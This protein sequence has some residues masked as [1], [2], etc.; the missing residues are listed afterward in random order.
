MKK[1]I[2]FSL[3]ILLGLFS[4]FSVLGRKDEYSAEK[5]FWHISQDFSKLTKDAKTTPD[6]AFQN[7]IIQ[8]NK[9]IKKFPDSKLLPKIYILKAKAYIF[10][11]EY[12]EARKNL[13]DVIIKYK[14]YPQI[15]VKALEFILQSY[16]LEGDDE[17]ILKTYDRIIKDYPVTSLGLK[18]PL[19]ISQF[20]IQK[21]Q[22]AKAKQA[23]D[24]A[25]QHYLALAKEYSESPVQYSILEITVTC[26]LSQK[27]WKQAV[28]L[29]AEMLIKFPSAQYLTTLRRK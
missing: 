24:D 1:T 26:Y 14:D 15:V 12:K 6:A 16:A 20:Y 28:N 19:L 17:D 29:L 23:L 27:K 7:I 18:S 8:Y 25:L 21:K 4:L 11:K 2:I 9:F 3:I 10:K 22:E 13:E 5:D